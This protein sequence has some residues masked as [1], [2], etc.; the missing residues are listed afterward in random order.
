MDMAVSSGAG[1]AAARPPR[2]QSSDLL[3]VIKIN[4]EIKK[5][6]L[7]SNEVNLTALNAKFMAHKSGGRA[8]GFGVVSTELRTFS[9]ELDAHMEGLEKLVFGLVSKVAY[10]QK[11]VRM[12][13]HLANAMNRSSARH[14]QVLR[15]VLTP[16]SGDLE[17]ARQA[18]RKGRNRFEARLVRAL[19][20][21]RLGSAF[22]QRAKVEAVYG[23]ELAGTL[24]QVSNQVEAAV[25]KTLAIL[26]TIRTHVEGGAK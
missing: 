15:A 1:R 23:S 9:K 19:K 7:I 14:Q 26:K 20:L 17:Q 5:V 8:V 24:T 12:L 18:I 6:V 22:A 11:Q 4:E 2:E 3:K 21:C 10:V 13:G 25:E 16:K